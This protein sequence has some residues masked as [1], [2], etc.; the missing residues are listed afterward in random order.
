MKNANRH[1]RRRPQINAVVA[2][3]MTRQV[4][5]LD[6]GIN[7]T[8]TLGELM[9]EA[10][11]LIGELNRPDTWGGRVPRCTSPFGTHEWRGALSHKVQWNHGGRVFDVAYP[12]TV[13][14]RHCDWII[15]LHIDPVDPLEAYNFQF[16][17]AGHMVT[18]MRG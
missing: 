7:H 18:Y 14:C 11:E 12:V 16:Q 1:S 3:T 8:A 17:R 15:G 2:D 9:V 10:E 5:I 13:V 6:D 4:E